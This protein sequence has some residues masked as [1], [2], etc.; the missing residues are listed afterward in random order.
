M[1][2]FGHMPG[3]YTSAAVVSSPDP[4]SH[5]QKGLVTIEG[6]LGCA[7]STNFIFEQMIDN[8]FMM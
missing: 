8:L 5:K 4:T 2:W 3:S 6:F 1:V 7:E